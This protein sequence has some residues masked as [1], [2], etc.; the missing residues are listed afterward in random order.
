MSDELNQAGVAS[1]IKHL[2]LPMPEW[3]GEPLEIPYG[4]DLTAEDLEILREEL[5]EQEQIA[6]N[7]AQPTDSNVIDLNERRK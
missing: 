1:L 4:G 3:L 6:Q 2:G 5:L 7:D